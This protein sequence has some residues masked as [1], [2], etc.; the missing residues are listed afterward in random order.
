MFKIFWKMSNKL[1]IWFKLC[2]KITCK[3]WTLI[4]IWM[5]Q[6]LHN[7]NNN[8]YLINLLH[9]RSKLRHNK[10][11]KF[12]EIYLLNKI[13]QKK[14]KN[15]N[16]KLIKI[17][18]KMFLFFMYLNLLHSY[19]LKIILIW[20]RHQYLKLLKCIIGFGNFANKL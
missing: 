7:P 4:N 13:I 2:I 6:F 18:Y 8:L 5:K 15:N 14:T 20:P 16:N 12:P 9:F 11:I 1:T 19:F 10:R 17:L 3:S